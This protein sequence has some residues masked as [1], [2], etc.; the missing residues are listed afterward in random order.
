MAYLL[1]SASYAMA[2]ILAG[3]ALC[4]VPLQGPG[5]S[6]LDS[7]PAGPFWTSAASQRPMIYSGAHYY[8]FFG[9][10]HAAPTFNRQHFTS[11]SLSRYQSIDGPRSGLP[12][13]NGSRR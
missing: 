11:S 7:S 8:L 1:M 5:K 3:L 13:Y 6:A 12:R 2:N 4:I 10:S 9:S